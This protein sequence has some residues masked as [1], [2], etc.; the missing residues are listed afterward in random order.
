MYCAVQNHVAEWSFSSGKTY[1]DPFNEVT[2]DVVFTDPDGDEHRVPAFWGGEQTWRVRY[3][4]PKVGT[5]HWRSVC[6]DVSDSGLHGLRSHMIP[7]D[8]VV[9]MG[10]RKEPWG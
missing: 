2:L 9:D 5:H 7:K 1:G 10:P 8:V 4:S 3:A 6:S